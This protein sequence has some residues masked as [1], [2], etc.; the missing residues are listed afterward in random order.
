MPKAT[1]ESLLNIS[2][3]CDKNDATK[4]LNF[5]EENKYIDNY[6]HSYLNNIKELVV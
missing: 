3:Q 1:K 5:I 2:N 6:I 4:L